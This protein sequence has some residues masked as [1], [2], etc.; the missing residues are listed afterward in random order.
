MKAKILFSFMAAILLLGCAPQS[1]EFVPDSPTGKI[2]GTVVVT[3]GSYDVVDGD[4][5][6][7]D[8]IGNNIEAELTRL[9]TD[10][11]KYNVVLY[12]V[13]FSNHMP[14][15]ID[16]TI[17]AVDI[18]SRG[19]LSGDSIVPYAGLLGEYPKFT[20]RNLTGKV[21][22]NAEGKAGALTL[23]MLCGKYPTTYEGI[24]VA[25]SK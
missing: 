5:V 8:Y 19:Y 2:I 15:T 12:K 3:D 6:F 16:M 13:C 9:P 17:P 1:G 24:Y 20:I 14:V 4:T 22:F 10:T 21:V 7:S 18:D 25:D 23:Q 11:T